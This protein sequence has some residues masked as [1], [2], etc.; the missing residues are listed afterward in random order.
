LKVR[1]R[2]ENAC[3]AEYLKTAIDQINQAIDNVTY[4]CYPELNQRLI[5]K[6]REAADLVE[7]C[8]HAG[9]FKPN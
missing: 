4:T 6:L 2:N 5:A 8:S 7:A 3:Y 1:N 9:I